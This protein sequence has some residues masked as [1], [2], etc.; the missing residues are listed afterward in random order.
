M[1]THPTNYI[2]AVFLIAIWKVSNFSNILTHLLT[3]FFKVWI[4]LIILPFFK[5]THFPY[6]FPNILH[7]STSTFIVFTFTFSIH[8]KAIFTRFR[9]F[10][11]ISQW[12]PLF[13]HIYRRFFQF[14]WMNISFRH[15]PTNKM[16][17][18]NQIYQL[19]Y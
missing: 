17:F 2:A 6:T 13:L 11:W 19:N 7:T 9:E 1:P 3:F 8:N 14:P 4:A 16:I 15:H 5:H 12:F 10:I 18:V